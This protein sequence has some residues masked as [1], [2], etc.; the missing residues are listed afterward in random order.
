MDVSSIPILSIV[1]FLPLIGVLV[2]AFAPASLARPLALATALI[3]FA[4]SLILL[5]GYSPGR[6]G[7]EF[8]ETYSW[9]PTFGIEYKLGAI[10][11]TQMPGGRRERDGTHRFHVI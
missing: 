3:T 4:V 6:P 7:F 2:I 9:I 10:A 1:T 5:I 8:V 11:T